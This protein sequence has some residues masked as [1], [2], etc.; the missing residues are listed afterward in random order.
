[1]TLDERFGVPLLLAI[2]ALVVA[3]VMTSADNYMTVTQFNLLDARQGERVMLDYDRIIKRDFDGEWRLDL[4]LNGVWIAA[5]RSPGVHTY[6]TTAKLPA[7][8]AL[9]LDWL[10]FND[11]AFAE[12]P[13]GDYEAAVQWIINPES[14]LWRRTV[15]ARDHFMVTCR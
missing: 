9:D 7:P 4:Y 10:S 2:M 3:A 1:M 12:L 15:E 13:C 5:A 14:H 8:D 6:R 11:P